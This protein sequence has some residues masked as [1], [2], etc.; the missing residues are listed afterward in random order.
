MS[1]SK[2]NRPATRKG[3]AKA[4]KGGG[5]AAKRG[6]GREETQ[7]LAIAI[8]GIVFILLFAIVAIAEGVGPPSIPSGAIAVIQDV[9]A[10]AAAPFE[11]PYTDCKGKKVSQDLGVVTEEEY[12]CAFEQLGAGS[13]LK[14]PPKPGEEQ[15]E[16]LHEG[17]ITSLI[18]NIWLQALAAEEGIEATAK[19]IKED[20]QKLIKKSFE[21]KPAKFKE[22]LKELPLHR[23]DVI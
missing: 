7:R 9:P 5:G 15:Y 6:P 22:F 8:F 23:T 3:A 18:E 21:G 4:G 11:K 2:G 12:N 1:P 10:N 14:K 13:G 19:D 17:A 16:A 20:E